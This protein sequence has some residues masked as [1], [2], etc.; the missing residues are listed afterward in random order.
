MKEVIIGPKTWAAEN[1]NTNNFRNGD[2][3][4]GITNYSK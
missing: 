1:L 3:I 2:S 4:D